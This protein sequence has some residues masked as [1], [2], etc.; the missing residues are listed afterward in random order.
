MWPRPED[1]PENL[2]RVKQLLGANTPRDEN[3]SGS[4][5]LIGPLPEVVRWVHNVLDPV[6]QLSCKY[7]GTSYNGG[8]YRPRHEVTTEQTLTAVRVVQGEQ[9][10]FSSIS[11]RRIGGEDL[12]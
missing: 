7:L 3:D 8:G 4:A 9:R 1:T 10:T 11:C 6:Q 5:I 2:Q 12:F